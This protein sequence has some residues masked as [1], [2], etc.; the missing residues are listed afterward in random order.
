MNDKFQNLDDDFFE[1]HG[2]VFL[3]SIH[4]FWFGR[5]FD[6][7]IETHL[8]NV[9]IKSNNDIRGMD[10]F[11]LKESVPYISVSSANIYLV[12]FLEKPEERQS[13]TYP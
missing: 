5:I 4:T 3:E 9:P 12:L 2:K 8:I 11:L 6:K 10:I 1:R 7:D 13:D